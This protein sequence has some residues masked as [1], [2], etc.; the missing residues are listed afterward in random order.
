MLR[1]IFFAMAAVVGVA[2]ASQAAIIG[3]FELLEAGKTTNALVY[4]NPFDTWTF[5]VL[6]DEGNVTS[7][8]IDF[9]GNFLNTNPPTTIRNLPATNPTVFGFEA[10]ETFALIPQGA[11]PLLGASV[12]TNARLYVSYTTAGGLVIAPNGVKT[13][14]AFFSV[15]VGTQLSNETMVAGS[16]GVIGGVR[17]PITFGTTPEIPEPSTI[18]LAGLAL[19][20]IVGYAR[21]RK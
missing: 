13:P 16:V 2:S 18:A 4:P 8:D 1:N 20:G 6:S 11:A 19:V 12:D 3:S 10:P 14:V 9:L 7:F 15:P 5:S 21:R 17:V